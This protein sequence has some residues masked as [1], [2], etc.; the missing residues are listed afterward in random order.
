MV[1]RAHCEGRVALGHVADVEGGQLAGLRHHLLLIH[2]IHQ[3]LL[4]GQALDGGEIEAVHVVPEVDLLVP[5][6]PT[7][8]RQR[9][10]AFKAAP[11]G[12][13]CVKICARRQRRMRWLVLA[14]GS[15]SDRRDAWRKAIT[16]FRCLQSG[17]VLQRGT[18]HEKWNANELGLP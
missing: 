16:R 1:G 17:S 13:S 2:H 12:G 15:H 5:A 8:M 9:I 11:N 3:W 14:S 4:H 18:S 6:R 7:E 10:M